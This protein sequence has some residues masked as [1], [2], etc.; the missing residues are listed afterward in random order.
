MIYAIRRCKENVYTPDRLRGNWTG[1]VLL[2]KIEYIR[3]HLLFPVHIHIYRRGQRHWTP[4]Y[5]L[6]VSSQCRSIEPYDSP[7]QRGLQ[8]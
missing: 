8:I 6:A 4:T 7:S 3:D 2:K 1:L 5:S